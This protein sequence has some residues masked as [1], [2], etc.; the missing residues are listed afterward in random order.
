MFIEIKDRTN[1]DILTIRT[2]DIKILKKCKLNYLNPIEIYFIEFYNNKTMI[3]I[4]KEDYEKLN[5]LL[6]CCYK[7]FKDNIEYLEEQKI[8]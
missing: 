5:D 4:T 2:Q 7:K 1:G 6:L 8:I 3:S